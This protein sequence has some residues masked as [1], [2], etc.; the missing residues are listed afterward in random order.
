MLSLPPQKKL[1][2]EKPPGAV[3]KIFR[4][5]GA[6]AT[7]AAACASSGEAL[8]IAESLI[9]AGKASRILVIGVEGVMDTNKDG[10][11]RFPV[12][13]EMYESVKALSTSE[14]AHPSLASRPFDY[15]R[16]GF[17]PSEGAVALFLENIQDALNRGVK[18][19]AKISTMST[20]NASG[21]TNPDE[22][23]MHRN[24]ELALDDAEIGI[25]EIDFAV[26]H[27]T[28][29]PEGDRAEK[30]ALAALLWKRLSK[31]P[32]SAIKSM[33]GHMLGAA[34][35]MGALI[36]V[37]AIRDGYIPPTLNFDHT[38]DMEI[39]PER[40]QLNLTEKEVNV[41]LYL[42]RR[43]LQRKVRKVVSNSFGFA[44]HNAVTIISD[45][46]A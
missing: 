1:G 8:L 32:M 30:A 34:G 26:P 22:L 17:I 38:E 4:L 41:P 7:I 19:L 27:A 33:T 18:P 2:L 14:H 9:K 29:T 43:A 35:A 31:V 39:T 5:R 21:D 40:E 28:S 12:I 37:L 15:R 10:T 25:D 46:A 3:A 45:L 23:V 44:G 6:S 36:S 13:V 24:F 16:D 42:P 11:M 20:N